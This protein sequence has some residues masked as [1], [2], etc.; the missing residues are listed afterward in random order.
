MFKGKN[1]KKWAKKLADNLKK[2]HNGHHKI[3]MTPQSLLKRNTAKWFVKKCLY[4][5]DNFLLGDV[6]YRN[7]NSISFLPFGEASF[8]VNLLAIIVDPDTGTL[9]LNL[10]PEMCPNLDPD[11]A[12]YWFR[13]LIQVFAHGYVWHT[14]G[15]VF[16]IAIYSF[17]NIFV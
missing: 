5:C 4:F 2:K 9:Y 6:M 10:D 12:P 7:I 15:D 13:I 11:P 8:P 17:K 1:Y 14:T 3:M 16:C